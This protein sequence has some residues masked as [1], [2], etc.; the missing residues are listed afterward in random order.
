M[1][2]EARA[3]VEESSVHQALQTEQRL[4]EA[5]TLHE[6]SKVRIYNSYLSSWALETHRAT[7]R[8]DERL[9]NKEWMLA[10][11]FHRLSCQ[12]DHQ[13]EMRDG[14]ASSMHQEARVVNSSVTGSVSPVNVR[15]E[16]SAA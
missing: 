5:Q 4:R 10:N 11:H 7:E 6:V 1:A 3:F 2:N 8:E 14:T 15:M 9:P 16:P 12:P 13:S